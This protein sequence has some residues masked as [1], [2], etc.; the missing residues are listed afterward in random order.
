MIARSGEE[1]TVNEWVRRSLEIA[2]SPGY[3]DKLNA[4]YPADRPP[5]RPLSRSTKKAITQLHNEKR[6]DK[7]VSLLLAL[8]KEGHP[9]PFE[10]PYASLFRKHV[11]LLEKNPKTV[12]QIG[13]A[14]L[15]LSVKEIINGCERPP[16]INRIMGPMFRNWLHQYFPG[17]GYPVLPEGNFESYPGPAFLDAANSAILHYVA[18]KLGYDFK[19]GRD[20][21]ARVGKDYVI[22]EARF[23][24]TS[25]GSQNRDL[26]QTIDFA[27]SARVGLVPVA[28]VDGVAW[29]NKG[30]R[31]KLSNL[32]TGEIA[33]TAL[34]LEDFLKSLM[35]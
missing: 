25:G 30:Y 14:L 15:E 21:L 2:N 16:D 33:L 6:G 1:G 26:E 13:N 31:E 32:K 5:R 22:G 12:Q 20:F 28:V 34:A 8:E 10:H 35:R 3:L 24:S 7:L 4:I 19:R 23:F 18:E 17:R 9:F 29:F 27:R 11:D